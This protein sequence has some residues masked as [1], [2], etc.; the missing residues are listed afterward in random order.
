MLIHPVISLASGDATFTD[1]LTGWGTTGLAVA[2]FT[3]VFV[4]IWL[5]RADRRRAHEEQK[6]RQ[7]AQARL[8]LTATPGTQTAERGEDGYHHDLTFWF[9]NYGDRPVMD[10]QAEAWAVSDPLDK[11][12]TWGVNERIVLPGPKEPWPL[13]DL[14]TPGPNLSLR[15]WRYRWTDADGRKWCVDQREQPEPLRFTGQQPRPYT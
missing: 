2:T 1:Y 4:T 15:A 8:I 10:V 7:L 14:I 11:L 9:Q 3:A 6:E 5:A 12:P 13:H